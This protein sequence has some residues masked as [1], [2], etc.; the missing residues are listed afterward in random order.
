MGSSEFLRH[1]A[2]QQATIRRVQ[3]DGWAGIVTA[4]LCRGAE[5]LFNRAFRFVCHISY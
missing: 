2:L 1:F 3:L 5:Q 4:L